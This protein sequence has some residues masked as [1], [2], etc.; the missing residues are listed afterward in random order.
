V[1]SRGQHGF[2]GSLGLQLAGGGLDIEW[3]PLE[4]L[5][6][7]AAYRAVQRVGDGCDSGWQWRLARTKMPFPAPSIPCGMCARAASVACWCVVGCM[8][9]CDVRVWRPFV[10]ASVSVCLLVGLCLLMVVCLSVVVCWLPQ[11]QG[12]EGP[13]TLNRNH[14]TNKHPPTPDAWQHIVKHS[15]GKTTKATSNLR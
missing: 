10:C 4:Q 14:S 9:W 2:R 8:V 12:G 15:P 11:W 3:Y 1:L 13:A 6:T 7:T 5:T